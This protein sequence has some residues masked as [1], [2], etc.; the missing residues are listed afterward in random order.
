MSEANVSKRG[1]VASLGGVEHA[2]NEHPFRNEAIQHRVG[3]GGDLSPSGGHVR[4]HSRTPTSAQPSAEE[5]DHG[6]EK[7]GADLAEAATR[8]GRSELEELA[9]KT[10]PSPQLV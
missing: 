8:G 3:A 7:L 2:S 5:V 4:E 1:F 9:E 6:V 10:A